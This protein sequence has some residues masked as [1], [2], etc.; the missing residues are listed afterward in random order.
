[1][2]AIMLLL[3]TLESIVVTRRLGDIRE[4][5]VDRSCPI[6]VVSL[7]QVIIVLA[8][9]RTV[10][11]FI[12]PSEARRKMTETHSASNELWALNPRAGPKRALAVKPVQVWLGSSMSTRGS[13]PPIDTVI[14]I[15][16]PV[17][18]IAMDPNTVER[19]S[20]AIYVVSTDGG[21]DDGDVRRC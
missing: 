16:F 14:V 12:S 18:V 4:T 3:N 8:Q 2:T 5:F 20:C 17:N 1:M 11:S 9:R 10:S 7:V 19:S 13:G 15:G 21:G 6:K